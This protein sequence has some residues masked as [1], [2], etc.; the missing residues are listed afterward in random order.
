[1]ELIPTCKTS[2]DSDRTLV[3]L[4]ARCFYCAWSIVQYPSAVQHHRWAV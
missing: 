4:P 2:K 1:M 3:N